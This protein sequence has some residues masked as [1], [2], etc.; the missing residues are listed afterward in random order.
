MS[1]PNRRPVSGPELPRKGPQLHDP[2]EAEPH[3]TSVLKRTAIWIGAGVAAALLL[4]A[5]VVAVVLTNP[6][7]HRYVQSTLEKQVSAS[8]GVQVNLQDFALHLSSLSVDLYGV[9]IHG[10]QPYANPPLLQVEHL[11]AGIGIT[12]VWK[13]KWY[14]NEIEIDRPVVRVFVDKNGVSNL[15]K[16]KTS[17]SSS[18]TTVFDLGIRHAVLNHGE[19]SYN[20][21]PMTLAADLHDF[22]Y[23]GSFNNLL[24]MYSGR[25][26]YQNGQI[27]YGSYRPLVHNVEA[28]FT[29]TPTDFHLSQAKIVSGKSAIALSASLNN[30]SNPRVDG[31][32]DARVDGVQVGE[33]LRSTSIPVGAVH[34]AGTVHYQQTGTGSALEMLT[35]N[36]SLASARL[37]VKASSFAANVDNLAANYSLANG[38]VVVQD[39]HANVLGGQL[40]VQGT[41]KSLTGNTHS[42]VNAAIHGVSLAALRQSMGRA[43][44]GTNLAV[45]GTLNTT[46]TAS[47]GKTFD[48]LIAKA[49]VDLKG[50]VSKHAMPGKPILAETA[51]PA[52]ARPMPETI[53]IASE[54][55]AIYSGA[56]HEL[57]LQK[58]FVHTPQTNLAL[59]GTVGNRSSL[60]LDL[61]ANDL[62]EV[63]TIADLFRTPAPGQP[64]QALDVA[65]QATFRGSLQGSTI[66]PH[67][68][69]QLNAQALRV[70]GTNWKVLRTG[71]D[72]SPSRAALQNAE[73]ESATQGRITLNASAGLTKWAWSNTSPIQADIKASDMSVTEV[74]RLAGQDLPV[75]GALNV[76][77]HVHGTGVNPEGD[78]DIALTKG[79]A[80]GEP[81][82]SVN[83]TLTGSGE[84][85]H[86]NLRIQ[87]PAGS[88]QGTV[89]VRPREKTYTAH[90]ASDGIRLEQVE[91]LKARNLDATGVLK[92]NADGQGSFDNPGLTASL[93]IP[94]LTMQNQKISGIDLHANVANHVAN[95][96]LTSSAIHTSLQ[97]KARIELTGEY[98][99]DASLDT[100]KISLQTLLAAYSPENAENVSGETEVHATLHG[101]LKNR[102]LL[103][104]H[105][106]I[107]EL[108]AAYNNTIQL[109][110][111]SPI[112]VD[113]QNN[114]IQI[115]PSS[116]KGTDTDLQFEG[117]IPLSSDAPMSVKLLGTMDLQLA[118]LFNPDLRSS[119]Q[120]KFNINSTGAVKG[121]N[122]GGEIDIVDASLA[123]SDAPVGLQH[124]NGVLT[125]TTNRVNISKFEGT[126]GGGAVTAQGGIVY[127]PSLQF[128]LGLA[129]KGVRALY[130]QGMR[131]TADAYLRFTGTPEKALLGGT[132]NLADISFTPAFDL[133]SFIG[134][135]SGGAIT[136]PSSGFSQDVALN[137][138]VHSTSNVNLVSRTVSI[139]GSA[140]LQVRGTAGD[141]VLLGRVNLDGGDVILNGTRFV[142]T[143]GT[144]QFINPSET[145]PVVNM[146][147]TTTIQQY[148][149]NMRFEGPTS[150]LKTQ[151]SSD[152]A[153][154]QADIINLLA[155]GQTTEAAA[156]NTSTTN[157]T[158]ES[159]VASQVSSQ[160]TSRVSKIAGISQLSINPVLAG[161]NAQGPPGANVTIQQRVTSNLFVT[162][163][164]NVASTQSQTIQG[165]YQ[166]SPRVAVS[167]TRDP[168]GGFAVDALIKKSW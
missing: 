133:N 29:A 69:G 4:I 111:A 98:M 32:Y 39:L 77:L 112:R 105:V 5:L 14:F 109:A 26:S 136:P 123:T 126:V 113:F 63:G 22:D 70:H 52:G 102:K 10:A 132:V 159:L 90:L 11:K 27:V 127:R 147:L 115:Q 108:K 76:N 28:Q 128:D 95:A 158:A 36:G 66:A 30:Y 91:A 24:Q 129:A 3:R 143:G 74:E 164:T 68:T 81:Y 58:S 92:L 150:Q 85:A 8:L 18:S 148:N 79:S 43:A 54:L 78:G 15:P 1:S 153:L 135:F 82:Q 38:D 65:G 88:V 142:L 131:E 156:Q 167:A 116:I 100:Q 104:A 97:A 141:P 71:L 80:Y 50:Q 46:A 83:V 140:N 57:G 40:R 44:A 139:G 103:E 12:S 86:A 34:A 149:I 45:A 55:H 160:V 49:D 33:I 137:I 51:P 125:L 146:A 93:Q 62:R 48:D 155:F 67:L 96:T 168:N 64:L 37:G 151:Y 152:P 41:M 119:G 59:N 19:V 161:S 101:P 130:P 162:F 84:E 53:A 16:P 73:L 165:Q 145:E 107:P 47:W 20:D 114:V 122:L 87:I 2:S 163:S 157:Q 42:T 99:T 138:A 134:Q 75:S 60:A 61:Q 25:L 13:R 117:S 21:R 144:V 9:T 6:S 35:V 154:P 72:V 121:A 120:V 106:T 23:Q 118:Q 89:S 110:A 17:S 124:G 56:R 166:V 7:L 31:Q 94:T